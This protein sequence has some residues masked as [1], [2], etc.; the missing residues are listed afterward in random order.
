MFS[1]SSDFMKFNSLLCSYVPATCKDGIFLLA[2]DLPGSDNEERL[3]VF[4]GHF[5]KGSSLKDFLHFTQL[6]DSKR[7]QQYD[8]GREKNLKKYKRATPPSYPMHEIETNVTL[9][10]YTGL[11]DKLADVTDVAH[12]LSQLNPKKVKYNARYLDGYGHLT[13]YL[14]NREHCYHTAQVLR[15]FGYSP[16]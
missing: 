4:M 7:F 15:D 10:F 8:Y 5:P 2:D 11:A 9:N 3:P 1:L 6:M 14:G 12:M 13:F 16:K